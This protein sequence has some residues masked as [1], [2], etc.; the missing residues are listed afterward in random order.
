MQRLGIG[1]TLFLLEGLGLCQTP[2]KT[3]KK[4]VSVIGHRFVQLSYRLR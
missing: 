4:K 3:P 2:G 1:N